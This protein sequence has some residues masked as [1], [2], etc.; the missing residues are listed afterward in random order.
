MTR[1]AARL[2][3]VAAALLSTSSMSRLAAQRTITVRDSIVLQ[4]SGD[5]FLALPSPVVSDGAGGYLVADHG[6][7][8]V[9][10]YS[11]DGRLMRRYG[12]EGE[13]PGEWREADIALPWGAAHVMVLSWSPYAIQLFRRGDGEFA[14]RHPLNTPVEWV[15]PG[16]GELWLSGAHYAT[17][18]AIRRLTVGETEARPVLPLPDVYTEGGPLGG[19]FNEMPFAMWADTLMV[20]FMPLP[21]LIVAD[22]TGRELDRFEVPTARRKGGTADPQAAIDEWLGSGRS[23]SGVFGLFSTTRG[24]HRRPDGTTLVI[25]FD[26]GTESAPASTLGLWVSVVDES[27]E[28]A[29]VDAAIP[30]ETDSR[31]AIGFEGDLFLVLEQ[32]LRGGDSVALLRR[33]EVDTEE[34]DWLPVGR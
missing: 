28:S 26:L 13:G 14:E 3:M 29:C 16:T 20:G 10:H 34:C 23:Y 21:Y 22:T 17:R 25:H 11:G 2:A 32:V 33:F 15:V 5:D 7:A 18:S 4:E 27:R 12:R 1:S 8:T 19:I 9:F 24:V 6:Q 30:L 31:A